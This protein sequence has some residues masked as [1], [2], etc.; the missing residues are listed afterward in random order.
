MK[1][2]LLGDKRMNFVYPY[3]HLNKYSVY[4]RDNQINR[5]QYQRHFLK[6]YVEEKI[7]PNLKT[8]CASFQSFLLHYSPIDILSFGLYVFIKPSRKF[9]VRT[10]TIMDAVP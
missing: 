8:A 2:I 6:F 7:H 4:G 9:R 5:N 1:S 10:S 3:T